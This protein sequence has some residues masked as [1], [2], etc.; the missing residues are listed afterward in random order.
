MASGEK[1]FRRY[2]Y[3][4]NIIYFVIVGGLLK[5]FLSTSVPDKISRYFSIP[6]YYRSLVDVGITLIVAIVAL[7]IGLLAMRFFV[8][9]YRR[10]HPAD[11][12]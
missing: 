5:S 9:M 10:R 1:K 2:L 8:K 7:S 4:L 11:R 3:V 6:E 12:G